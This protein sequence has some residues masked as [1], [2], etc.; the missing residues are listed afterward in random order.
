VK[1]VTPNEISAHMFRLGKDAHFVDSG[2]FELAQK[3]LF[4]LRWDSQADQRRC[5]LA[6]QR[7]LPRSVKGEGSL[8]E[9][10]SLRIPDG[11]NGD[12]LEPASVPGTG[13][14]EISHNP[15]RI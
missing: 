5:L 6:S 7:E 13:E 1:S 9:H 11:V 12:R 14:S 15:I 3:P 2:V 4:V 10:N 8:L